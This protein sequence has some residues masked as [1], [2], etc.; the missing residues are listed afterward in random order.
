MMTSLIDDL[1]RE[2]EHGTQV[3]R[4]ILI[5]VGV[6]VV[7]ALL[8]VFAHFPGSA[9]EA[10]WWSILWRY[11]TLSNDWI[12]NLKHIWVFGTHMFLHIGFWHILWNM[13]FIYWFGRR[14]GDWIGDK[15]IVPL[16][17]YGGLASAVTL[18]LADNIFQYVPDGIEVFAHGASGA[19]MAYVVAA[20]V[21]NPDAEMNLILI[22][23]VKLKYISAVLVFFDII[24]LGSNVNTGGHFGHLGGALMGWFYIYALRNGWNLASV[25]SWKRQDNAGAK[26]RQMSDVYETRSRRPESGQSIRKY[27]TSK[28]ERPEAII[29]SLD[30]EIDRILDK[31]KK[32]GID[33]L[34]EAERKTLDQASEK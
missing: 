6:Y 32:E 29:R 16:Y 2:F 3:T 12:F 11:T 7:M 20:A 19:A 17:L 23:P 1:K 18:I 30:D 14:V 34:T 15:H 5:N 10:G 27:F 13:L 25:F 9:G 33:S 24:A 31:I 26:V 4:L 22:G 21:I 8:N 28:E